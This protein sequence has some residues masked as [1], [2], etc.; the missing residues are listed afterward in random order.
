MWG[1]GMSAGRGL[2][3]RQNRCDAKGTCSSQHAE[4]PM[5]AC[6]VC[7][8]EASPESTYSWPA[9]SAYIWRHDAAT[10]DQGA[11]QHGL[12]VGH[13]LVASPGIL[14]AASVQLD[15]LQLRAVLCHMLNSICQRLAFCCGQRPASSMCGVAQAGGAGEDVRLRQCCQLRAIAATEV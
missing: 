8:A 11:L 14:D 7:A 12:Q 10:G 15:L 1:E 6:R 4:L 13:I 2:L 3:D 9:V 5:G